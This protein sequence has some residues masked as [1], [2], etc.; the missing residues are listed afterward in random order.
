MLS[1]LQTPFHMIKEK[2]NRRCKIFADSL[3]KELMAPLGRESILRAR[4]SAV[5]DVPWKAPHIF[6]RQIWLHSA[7]S[8]LTCMAVAGSEMPGE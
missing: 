2:F 4:T 8:K 7:R 6:G 3:F 5:R 1:A